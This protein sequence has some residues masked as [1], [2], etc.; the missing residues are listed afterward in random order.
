MRVISTN[1]IS[2]FELKDFGAPGGTMILLKCYDHSSGQDFQ[3]RLCN[4]PSNCWASLEPIYVRNNDEIIILDSGSINS[5]SGGVTTSITTKDYYSL[6]KS[7]IQNLNLNW[8]PHSCYNY[9]GQ[10]SRYNVNLEFF[11]L[12]I[13]LLHTCSRRIFLLASNK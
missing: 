7:G 2:C 4:T 12:M 3:H 11:R 10:S 6:S 1:D 9:K 8:Q 13:T 5:A